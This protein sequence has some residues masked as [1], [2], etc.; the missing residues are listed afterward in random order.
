MSSPG[1]AGPR[2]PTPAGCATLR[3]AGCG[4]TGLENGARN[5][6]LPRFWS[7]VVTMDSSELTSSHGHPKVPTSSRS[8]M[9]E[10]DWNPAEEVGTKDKRD[11]EKERQSH[12]TGKTH[13]HPGGGDSQ[14]GE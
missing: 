13:P 11:S 4:D 7:R 12:G 8:T 10:K 1:A 5:G 3:C 14:M 9:D 6:C 2:P